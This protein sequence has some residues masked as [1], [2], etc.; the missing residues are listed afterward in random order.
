MLHMVRRHDSNSQQ[1]A[2]QLGDWDENKSVLLKCGDE[3]RTTLDPEVHLL[4]F[5]H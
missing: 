2:G 5:S 4:A 1:E 3:A